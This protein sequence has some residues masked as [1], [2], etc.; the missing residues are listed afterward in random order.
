M[1]LIMRERHVLDLLYKKRNRPSKVAG[2]YDGAIHSTN[3]FDYL[4]MHYGLDKDEFVHDLHVEEFGYSKFIQPLMW[5]YKRLRGRTYNQFFFARLKTI[6]E[7]A[8]ADGHIIQ[9]VRQEGTFIRE[10]FGYAVATLSPFYYP[11]KLIEY[12]PL[13]DLIGKALKWTVILA[14]GY[15]GISA[16]IG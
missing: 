1:L 4:R 3:Y 15:I 5:L 11:K 8:I 6:L 2:T 14:L 16:I 13:R 12:E 9:T 10:D 7:K